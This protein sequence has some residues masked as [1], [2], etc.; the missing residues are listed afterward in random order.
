MIIGT[1]GYQKF[2][3]PA[4]LVGQVSEILPQLIPVEG[5]YTGNSIVYKVTNLTHSI[6]YGQ[7]AYVPEITNEN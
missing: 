6:E 7:K 5:T 3:I 4:N 2:Q 1:I